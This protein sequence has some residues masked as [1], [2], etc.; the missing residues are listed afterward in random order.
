MFTEA[1][2]FKCHG[3]PGWTSS[4]LFYPVT[5]TVTSNLASSFSVQNPGTGIGPFNDQELIDEFGIGSGNDRNIQNENAAGSPPGIAPLQVSC[6]LR[7]VGSFGDSDNVGLTTAVEIKNGDPTQLAQGSVN[8][9]N[10]PNLLG[11]ALN[12]P[13]FHHGLAR[14]LDELL[15]DPSWADHLTRANPG[16][17]LQ[18]NGE[19]LDLKNFLLSIDA[20][21]PAF[22]LNDVVDLCDTA[23]LVTL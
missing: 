20:E 9:Y 13:Y 12:A 7:N 10:V 22:D 6:V 14:T 23:N 4:E 5:R 18:G 16:F 1:G 8:G 11:V 15:T 21:T 2:C 17:A 19:V 3:G